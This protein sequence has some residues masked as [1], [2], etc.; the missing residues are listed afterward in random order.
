MT[1]AYIQSRIRGRKRWET[2][3]PPCRDSWGTT[4]QERAEKIIRDWEFHGTANPDREYRVVDEAGAV[5]SG[6]G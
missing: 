4:G 3:I 1:T 5:V 6:D 2:H